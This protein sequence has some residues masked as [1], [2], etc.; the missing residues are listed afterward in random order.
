MRVAILV[1]VLR[2]PHNVAPL[3]ASI[4][5]ATPEAHHT[6]FI[7]S[8]GDTDELDAV[9]DVGAEHLTIPAYGLGDYA[10]KINAGFTATTEPYVFLGA[11][12]LRFHDGWFAAAHAE[13]ANRKIGVVGTQDLGNPRVKQGL[14]STHSLVRRSYIERYGTIDEPGK[15]LHEG[16]PHE[17]VDD[18]LVGTA[19]ARGAW[20]FAHD[21]VVEHLHPHW[22]K[23]PTDDLYG[24]ARSRYMIGRKLYKRRRHLWR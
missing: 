1:P 6:L 24:Q 8:E 22:G 15:V 13:M 7:C 4:E 9:T 20:A 2:R 18:E 5:G 17:F 12:D 10:K 11:D 3:V 16:Y 14:H 23:A 19:Q 21:S